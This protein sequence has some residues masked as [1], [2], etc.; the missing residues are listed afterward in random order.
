MGD[1]SFWVYRLE[2]ANAPLLTGFQICKVNKC[3]AF[4]KKVFYKDKIIDTFS[5]ASIWV[6]TDNG[7]GKALTP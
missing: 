1:K 3:T 4:F 6:K 5:N 7:T 2:G